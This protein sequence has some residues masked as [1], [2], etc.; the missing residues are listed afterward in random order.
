MK[1]EPVAAMIAVFLLG[2]WLALGPYWRLKM[3]RVENLA[4]AVDLRVGDDRGALAV[5]EKPG[6]EFAYRFIFRGGGGG[7]LG[8][9]MSKGDLMNV[10]PEEVVRR[11]STTRPNWLYRVLNIT[12]PASFWWVLVGLAAQLAFSARFLIQ[13]FVS[14]RERKTVI[15]EAF[16]WISLIG[17]AGLFAYFAWR[18]D[19]V[20][21]LGQS[22]GLVIYARN[23]RLIHKQ[24]RRASRDSAGVTPATAEPGGTESSG[25]ARPFPTD[26][27]TSSEH[28][29]SDGRA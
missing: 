5:I 14:E 24:K 4:Y 25:E 8:P 23:I 6:G 20:G 10:L 22:S 15:P 1:W 21:V 3:P 17:G 28:K 26:L 18:Q 11:I 13:W 9:E 19:I 29:A 27:E 2:A 7:G 16:W 12:N